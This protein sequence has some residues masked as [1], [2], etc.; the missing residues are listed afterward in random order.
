[1]FQLER[2]LGHRQR[3]Q[4]DRHDERRI[5]LGGYGEHRGHDATQRDRLPELESVLGCWKLP[6]LRI[7]DRAHDQ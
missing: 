7:G 2:L 3:R 6:N 1:M 4:G 5:E